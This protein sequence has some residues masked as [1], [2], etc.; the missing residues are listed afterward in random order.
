MSR[1]VWVTTP[2]GGQFGLNSRNVMDVLPAP[3]GSPAH[4]GCVLNIRSW[5]MDANNALVPNT[6]LVYCQETM[7]EMM[8]RLNA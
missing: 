3:N 6:H 8:D 5:Y 1:F 2:D 7:I 4:V